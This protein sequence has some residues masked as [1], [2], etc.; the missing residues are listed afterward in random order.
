[1]SIGFLHKFDYGNAT[2]VGLPAYQYDQQQPNIVSAAAR[3][4]AGMRHSDHTTNALASFHWLRLPQSSFQASGINISCAEWLDTHP[5]TFRLF[6][7][8][9]C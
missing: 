4:V 2:L 3:S 1:V 6:C 5:A 9:S 8:T 7:Y